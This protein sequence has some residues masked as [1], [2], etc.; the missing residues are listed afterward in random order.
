MRR[1]VK[2][3]REKDTL[4]QEKKTTRDSGKYIVKKIKLDKGNLHHMKIHEA[5][6]EMSTSEG[7]YQNDIMID[8]LEGIL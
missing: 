2:S 6:V 8:L 7:I 5:L 4:R 3:V 1:T